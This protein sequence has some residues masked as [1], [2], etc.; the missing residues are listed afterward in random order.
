MVRVVDPD[1]PAPGRLEL[2]R[3]VLNSDDRFHQV[4]HADDVGALDRYLAHVRPTHRVAHEEDLQTF[5]S[6]RDATRALL[7]APSP[8]VRTT[9]NEMAARHP[10][11]VRIE[12]QDLA[13]LRT[14]GP[15]EPRP[16][17]ALVGAALE[18]VHE[19]VLTGTWSRLHACRRFECG[20]I[21]YDSTPRNSM[22][23]C[24]TDP[25]GNVMK[26]RAY[27]ARRAQPTWAAE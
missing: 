11:T 14:A 26:T 5:R 10:V 19:A 7:L 25:C 21:Y 22:R 15:A 1:R 13:C 20:W 16:I 6:F 23:W 9:F 17:D 3:H 24:T 12:E 2:V 18:A 27:R 8:H 4:D